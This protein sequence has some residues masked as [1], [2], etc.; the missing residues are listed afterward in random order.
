MALFEHREELE[1]GGGKRSKAPAAPPPP[2]PPPPAPR[3]VDATRAVAMRGGV[4]GSTQ[5]EN[6]RNTGGGRGIDT[7]SSQRALK[8]LTGQ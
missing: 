2:A 6:I 4:P 7:A 8:S 3:Q 5:A 1:M